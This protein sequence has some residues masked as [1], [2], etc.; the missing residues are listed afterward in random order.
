MEFFCFGFYVVDFFQVIELFFIRN[1]GKLNLY[2]TP[3][4]VAEKCVVDDNPD[5][6]G[7]PFGEFC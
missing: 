7:I 5:E 2:V 1:L 6:S 4:Y 3:V